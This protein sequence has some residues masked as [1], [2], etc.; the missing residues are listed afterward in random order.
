[1]NNP[2]IFKVVSLYFT[3]AVSIETDEQIMLVFGKGGQHQIIA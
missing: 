3:D 1:M 2:F